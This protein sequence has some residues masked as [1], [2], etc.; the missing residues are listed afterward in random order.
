MPLDVLFYHA[1]ALC[2]ANTHRSPA[3]VAHRAQSLWAQQ[4]LG[5]N[6][7]KLGFLTGHPPPASHQRC[8]PQAIQR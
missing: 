5:T 2:A 3:M 1:L 6:Q 4:H 7:K 8:T